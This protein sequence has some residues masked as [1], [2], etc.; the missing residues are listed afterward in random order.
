VLVAVE[1]REDFT[2]ALVGAQGEAIAR[3]TSLLQRLSRRND[4]APRAGAD[5]SPDTP[6]RVEISEAEE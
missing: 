5:P 4:P 2:V 1:I 6:S 3:L